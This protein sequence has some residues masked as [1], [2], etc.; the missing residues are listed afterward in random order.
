MALFT[1]GICV[2]YVYKYVIASIEPCKTS[3][4]LYILIN[5]IIMITYLLM[6]AYSLVDAKYE[7]F[8]HNLQ[9]SAEY[10]NCKI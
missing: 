4:T 5:Q 3:G 1:Y 9:I 6:C 7:P 2:K 10:S 8:C